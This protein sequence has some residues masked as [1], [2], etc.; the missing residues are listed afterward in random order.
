MDDLL[1]VCG[2]AS[3]LVFVL[4]LD[5]LVVVGR[6]VVVAVAAVR[7]RGAHQVLEGHGAARGLGLLVVLVALVAFITLVDGGEVNLV[8]L[9]L[10]LALAGAVGAILVQGD[11]L[12]R[13]ARGG[14]VVKGRGLG[15]EDGG[16]LRGEAVGYRARQ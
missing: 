13:G 8:G 16:N 4:N 14:D 12:S 15:G 9:V 1:V 7:E 3:L 2:Y 11:V 5:V 6:G 10:V